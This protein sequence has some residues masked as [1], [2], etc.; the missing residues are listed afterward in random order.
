MK[1][2]QLSILG[3]SNGCAIRL[4]A[5]LFLISIFFPPGAFAQDYTQW[6]LPEG[7]EMR[8]GKGGLRGN[9]VFSPDSTLLDGY[10]GKERNLLTTHT[11]S[12]SSVA[13]SPDGKTLASSS[14]TEFYL[15][16]VDSG[17]HKATFTGHT[18]DI[19]SMAF[20]PDGKTLATGGDEKEG[21]VK[22]WDVDTGVLK[23]TLI[24]HTNGILTRQSGS[25]MLL[26]GHSFRHSAA[27]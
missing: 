9:I 25:G 3:Q 13:F 14:S 24:G 6:G 10:T 15:W 27:I 23:M 1:T 17:E 7:A 21:L 20:S 22:F 26:L 18:D 2:M 19:T 11:G 8:L 16:D 5:M 4:S 12:I